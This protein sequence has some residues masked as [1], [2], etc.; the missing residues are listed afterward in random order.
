M[1]KTVYAAVVALTFIGCTGCAPTAQK[2]RIPSPA[3]LETMTPRP[4]QDVPTFRDTTA[5]TMENVQA[6]VPQMTA[7]S[8]DYVDARIAEYSTKL[9]RWKTLD[10]KAVD[11]GSNEQQNQLMVRCF[12]RLQKVLNGYSD[13]RA[14]MLKDDGSV[15]LE[16]SIVSGVQQEDI[17]FVDGECGVLLA[18]PIE[19]T[20]DVKEDT[21]LQ[22]LPAVE[23]TIA[24]YSKRKDYENVLQ[25]WSELS[26]EQRERTSVAT[27]IFYGEALTHLHQEEKAVDVYRG[28]VDRMISS[29]QKTDILSLRKKI[30]DLYTA[31]GDFAAAEKQY[32]LIGTDYKNLAGLNDWAVLQLSI[33]A[34]S[35][36][37]GDELKAY[38]NLL[39]DYLS[40]QPGQDGYKIV[41]E[42]EKY[43][44]DYS[45]SP[46]ASNVENIKKEVQAAADEWYNGLWK[47]VENLSA[48]GRNEEAL[49]FLQTI[50]ID[51][52]GPERAAIVTAKSEEL[53]LADAVNRET[54]KMAGFQ[55][56][57]KKWNN[58]LLLVKGDRYDEAI[59]VFTELLGTEYDDKARS[60]IQEVSLDAAQVERRKAADTFIRFTTTTDVESQK[61][62]LI[63]SR[64]ILK[65]ILVK[66]PEVDLSDKVMKNIERVEAEMN[67][68]DPQLLATVKM[69]EIENQNSAGAPK[70][71]DPFDVF[72]QGVLT[73]APAVSAPVATENLPQ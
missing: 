48:D 47:T 33:L 20:V 23:A 18:N 5:V 3:P 34:R 12:R 55:E 70:Q 24:D 25:T 4:P 59:A 49:S 2:A 13:L 53:L 41:W 73:P 10:E 72:D 51:L 31:T 27:K 50:P 68:I 46:V 43:L 22:G 71:S 69:Q 39:K 62:L 15:E 58:G 26:D 21:V 29:E 42:A 7:I 16:S 66:Y 36:S 28:L 64:N 19:A 14:G 44:A 67:K 37:N 6:P 65:G 57:Q 52:I 30:A 45:L 54:Q 8:R 1:K 17:A 61:K 11:Q 56:L 63:E 38:S 40:F 9:D 35:G 32:D 60:K